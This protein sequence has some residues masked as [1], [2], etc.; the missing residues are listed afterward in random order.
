MADL[1]LLA[2]AAVTGWAAPPGRPAAACPATNDVRALAGRYAPREPNVEGIILIAVREGVLT[3]GPTF[4]RP[5]RVLV[6]LAA[7]SFQVEDRANRVVVFQRA[8]DGCI[9]S[10]RVAGLGFP[11]DLL[12]LSPADTAPVEHLVA[13]RAARAVAAYTGIGATADFLVAVAER[14][15]RVP[16]LVPHAPPF[17]QEVARRFPDNDRVEAALGSA[18]IGTG[19][20]DS[21]VVHF[22]RALTVNGGNAT[23]RAALE[24]LSPAAP[25]D[26][27]WVLPFSLDAL[28][29]QPTSQETRDVWREWVARD[30]SSRGVQAVLTRQVPLGSARATARVVSHLVHG[31][32]HFGVILVPEGATPG[33]CPLLLEAKGVSWDFFPLRVPEGL[34]SI[35]VLGEDQARFIYVV[36]SFRGEVLWV[37]SDSVRSEGD[38]RDAWDGAADDLLAL[39]GV[40]LETTPEAD[41][42]RVCVFG[43]SRGGAVALL[44]AERDRR[45]DCAV[46]WAAP[47][48]W[49]ELMG[50]AGWTQRELVGQALRH[51]AE[52]DEAGGQFINYFLTGA[53]D[54]RGDLAGTRRHIIASSPLYFADRLPATQIHY[55]TDDGI[56]PERN[57]R[58]LAQQAEALPAG[59][60]EAFFHQ[61]AGH[62]QDL[63]EAPRA[64]RRFLMR[65]VNRT[66]PPCLAPE[67]YREVPE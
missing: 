41:S 65:L 51:R 33:C 1:A 48:D 47:T 6:R 52:P 30:L 18:W 9:R 45:I 21:A 4:W 19:R 64:S 58:K 26:S 5:A 53:L 31:A 62:D 63:F 61:G 14:M 13:G 40:A 60:L 20:R 10:L 44:A 16:T 43:R 37:G 22:R 24:R 12:R 56:V 59:C 27:G 39:L 35:Q 50:S 54:D 36:P 3:I 25:S 8:P 34:T 49:F 32:R 46:A 23:A 11:G 57:G 66:L 7:D 29:Q 17:L 55:G 38:R 28:F 42:S 2:L 15:L 67:R